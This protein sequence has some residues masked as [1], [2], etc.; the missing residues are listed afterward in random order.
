MPPTPP[1]PTPSPAIL[2]KEEVYHSTFRRLLEDITT[3]LKQ[4]HQIDITESFAVMMVYEYE[5]YGK[6]TF[7]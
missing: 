6:W 2:T 3:T 4:K 5:Y 1:P 7:I